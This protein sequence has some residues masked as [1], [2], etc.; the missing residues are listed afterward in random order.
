MPSVPIVLICQHRLAHGFVIIRYVQDKAL[1]VPVAS[2]DF[3]HLEDEQ[4]RQC[5]RSIVAAALTDCITQTRPE[6]SQLDRMNDAEKRQFEREHRLLSAC[7]Q[8]GSRLWLDPIRVV[9]PG[10]KGHAGIGADF[11][12]V[13][14]W[15]T[16][17]ADFY[18]AIVKGFER[19]P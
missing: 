18:S 10:W 17:D 11:R 6:P 19:A 1:N 3:T 2:G 12:L 15:P 13:L 7:V 4:M 8:A 5:G 16:T 9:K 14:P